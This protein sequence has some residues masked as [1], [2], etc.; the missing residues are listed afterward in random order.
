ML[1]GGRQARV[2]IDEAAFTELH[3]ARVWKLICWLLLS[4]VVGA[5]AAN[6]SWIIS[7]LQARF[8]G[9]GLW[10]YLDVFMVPVLIFGCGFVLDRRGKNREEVQKKEGERIRQEESRDR[11]LQAYFDRLSVLLLDRQ[12]LSLV[13]S[14][15]RLGDNY[16]DPFVVV[17]RDVISA[18]TLAILRLFSKDKENRNTVLRFLVETGILQRLSVSLRSA[19][20]SGVYFGHVYLPGVDLCNADLSEADFGGAYLAGAWL[21]GAC[22]RGA[23]LRATL[24]NA[25]LN[26]ADLTGADFSGADLTGADLSGANLRRVKWDSDTIWPGPQSFEMATNI[27]RNL[28][29]I[30]GL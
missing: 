23:D 15:K 26:S 19:N 12:V 17:A 16:E 13:E 6:R 18:R 8:P 28:K 3:L 7:F 5:L 14:A 20:L 4:V 30:I 11:A 22:L 1:S 21:R 10:D 29:K 27:P 25:I 9:K 2:R 24:C